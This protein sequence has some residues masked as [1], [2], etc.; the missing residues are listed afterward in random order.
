MAARPRKAD[1]FI[2]IA[3]EL[4]R[5]IALANFTK[6]AN[7]ILTEVL[8]QIF[9]AEQEDAM[10]STALIAEEY[11]VNGSLVRRGLAELEHAGV[12]A[13]T[14]EGRFRFVKDYESWTSKGEPILTKA[15]CKKCRLAPHQIG[16]ILGS[17]TPVSREKIV[18]RK[19]RSSVTKSSQA[20]DQIVTEQ[21][22]ICDQIVTTSVTKSSQAH[23]GTGRAEFK[24]RETKERQI[25][26]TTACE[27]SGDDDEAA[28]QRAIEFQ[29]RP[30]PPYFTPEESPLSIQ[31]GKHHH[32]QVWAASFWR[33]LWAL[34]PIQSLL[35]GW[36]EVQRWHSAEVWDAAL[37]ECARRGVKVNG[38]KYLAGIAGDIERDGIPAPPFKPIGTDGASSPR[39]PR[40]SFAERDARLANE[41]IEA[42]RESLR[43]KLAK[44]SGA[45]S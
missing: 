38:Y 27:E 6:W 44:Y 17:S 34:N 22:P 12:L 28:K 8:P 33:K 39:A 9:N 7:V 25:T 32:D 43:R 2:P 14:D 18:T 4:H 30:C 16:S 29:R 31:H 20:C 40:E 41:A 3:H 45:Q 26:T 24:L 23:I 15:E 36:Y 13:R 21:N 11:G 35:S 19:R 1:G 42:E 37:A 5:A 10:I